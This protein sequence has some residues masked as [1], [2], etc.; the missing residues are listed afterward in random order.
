[1][2]A[3]TS[4]GDPTLDPEYIRYI[5]TT[6]KDDFNGYRADVLGMRD[7]IEW[8]NLVGTDILTYRRVAVSS[9]HGI[10][11]TGFAAAAI[12]WFLSTRPNPAINATANTETQLTTKLWRELAKVNQNA[13]N[14]SWFKWSATKFS[15]SETAFAAAIPWSENNP[16]AFAGT[17][18][19]YVLGVFDEAST[20]PAI[21]S[22]TFSGAMSTDGA[23]WLKLG[24]PT[25]N[26]G[27]FYECC[28][29]KLK[30]RKPGDELEG[31]WKAHIVGSPDSPLVSKQWIKEQEY[32]LGKDSDE[33]RVRILGLP[34]R[35]ASD[36]L[37]SPASIDRAMERTIHI[38]DRWPLVLGVDVARQGMDR[39]VI[40]PRRGLLV[41]DRIVSFNN[42]TLKELSRKIVE[43]IHW[44]REEHGL[45]PAAINIE[46]GGSL[47]WGVIED[48]W[49]WGY[50]KVFAVSPGGASSS[51]EDYVNKRCEMWGEAKK[52]LD[53]DTAQLPN[54]EPLF[55]DLIAPKKK[56]D[57]A[58]RLRLETKDEMKRR[59]VRSP[60]YGDAFALTFATPVDLL[61]DAS[62]DRYGQK[63][64]GHYDDNNW[65]TA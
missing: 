42:T 23:R 8:Q 13:K 48:L 22:T 11:K 59:G 63:E 41:P 36:Q 30:W 52:Y 4:Q 46:G 31:K 43:E 54:C 27:D 55:E 28:F 65:M 2:A 60:D 17:H 19:T 50:D 7:D 47:G 14:R 10:G 62:V 53:E 45:E 34:P 9:G 6:Y 18:E 38:N 51:P 26:T 64:D 32:A 15:L 37:I 40:C 29:G 20:I 24:N 5:V 3:L 49:E 44:W 25:E 35:E 12:H 21:I 57:A 61:P 33:Y 16:Q 56:P 1:M 39:S 58:L